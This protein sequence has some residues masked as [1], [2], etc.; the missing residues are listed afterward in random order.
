LSVVSISLRAYSSPFVYLP[1]FGRLVWLTFLLALGA[2]LILLFLRYLELPAMV[3]RAWA[4]ASHFVIFTPFLVSWTQL[5]VDGRKR[6]VAKRPFR[7]GPIEW[8]YLLAD[9]I[10]S[11][12]L[13]APLVG[14]ARLYTEIRVDLYAGNGSYF[15]LLAAI[16]LFLA[17]LLVTL[18]IFIRLS[19]P[20]SRACIEPLSGSCHRLETD[21]KIH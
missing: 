1:E 4:L 12:V 19:L 20:V 2:E 15:A 17:A 14:S 10:T 16:I 11:T 21:R 3:T 18:A 6:I 7:Y 5:M 9:A 8:R 13:L